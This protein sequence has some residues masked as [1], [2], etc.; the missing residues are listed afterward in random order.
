MESYENMIYFSLSLIISLCFSSFPTAGSSNFSFTEKDATP[1]T[2]LCPICRLTIVRLKGIK[3]FPVVVSVA[4]ALTRACR[5]VHLSLPLVFTAQRIS[6]YCDVTCFEP[7]WKGGVRLLR[8]RLIF[9]F[10]CRE[11][12]YSPRLRENNAGN[13]EMI[14]VPC[15]PCS[16]QKKLRTLPRSRRI[17]ISRNQNKTMEKFILAAPE[18]LCPFSRCP[19]RKRATASPGL[20]NIPPDCLGLRKYLETF[21]SDCV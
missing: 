1:M 9:H 2:G 14:A 17:C 16:R 13:I 10:R 6:H 5:Y 8:G 4:V 7:G 12:L 18:E 11:S 19:R 3:Q 20:R 21:D 15:H